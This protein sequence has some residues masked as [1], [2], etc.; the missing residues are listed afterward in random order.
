MIDIQQLIESG[1]LELHAAGVLPKEEATALELLAFQHPAVATALGEAHE[2]QQRLLGAVKT[3]P[4]KDLKRRVMEAITQESKQLR[5]G[6]PPML[7]PGSKASDFRPWLANM[8]SNPPDGME[9][10]FFLV[11]QEDE[12]VQTSLVWVKRL[13]AEEPHKDFFERLLILDGACMVDVEGEMHNLV[14]GDYFSVPRFKKHTIKV[15]SECPCKF[16]L[17]RV[18]A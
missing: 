6:L 15:T 2:A 18:V 1:L 8:D 4:S 16:I 9:D 11:I 13:L 5:A 17:Q 3:N 10:M 7:H 14:A 12:E